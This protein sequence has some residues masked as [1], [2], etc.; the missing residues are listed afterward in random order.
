MKWLINWLFPKPKPKT[1]TASNL[2]EVPD[3]WMILDM[4]QSPAHGLWYCHM[5]H[6]DDL[7]NGQKEKPRQV[8]CEEIDTMTDAMQFCIDK[9]PELEA[10]YGNNEM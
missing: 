2:P 6:W 4:G 3:K 8:W 5:V 10:K 1:V 7:L 9:I